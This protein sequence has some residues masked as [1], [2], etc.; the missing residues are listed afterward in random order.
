[1][2]NSDEERYLRQKALMNGLGFTTADLERN[3]A[4]ILTDTQRERLYELSLR[5]RRE[6][7]G[8][9]FATITAVVVVLVVGFRP[10]SILSSQAAIYLYGFIWI[11]LSYC[12]YTAFWKWR[13]YTEAVR[14]HVKAVRGQLR[15][16]ENDLGKDWIGISPLSITSKRF[17]SVSPLND[18]YTIYYEP[19]TQEILSAEWHGQVNEK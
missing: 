10:R 12:A 5:F 14:S 18:F 16:T 6:A 15:V 2:L 3:Q 8:Y 13:W 1:M 4:G 17:L 7:F 9:G 11:I 19:R